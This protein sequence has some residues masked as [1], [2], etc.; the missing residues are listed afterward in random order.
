MITAGIRFHDAC[1]GCEAFTLNQTRVHA[2]PHY[3]LKRL[4][5][6]I[7]VAK[8]AVA[9]DRE[10]RMIGSLGVQ[11]EAAEPTIG[12]MQFDFLAELPLKADTK[13]VADDQHPDHQLGVN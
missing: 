10:R 8:A 1:I 6:N 2:R 5:E 13:A 7:T 9:I 4:T 12:E 3:R 11:I